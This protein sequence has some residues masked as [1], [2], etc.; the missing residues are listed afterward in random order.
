MQS[1]TVAFDGADLICPTLTPGPQTGLPCWL[2]S[3][4][5]ADGNQ[6]KHTDH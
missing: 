6:A 5:S 1:L 3:R 4:S 2:S